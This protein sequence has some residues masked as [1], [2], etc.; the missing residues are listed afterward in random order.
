MAGAT[1][2]QVGDAIRTRPIDLEAAFDEQTAAV[3]F[4]LQAEML[5]ASLSLEHTLEIAHAHSIPVIVDAAAELPPKSNLWALAQRGAAL[6]LFSGGKDLRGPQTSGL[7]VG[8]EDLISAARIQ[9]APHE[10]VVGRPMK[11][12]KEIVMGML[13]AVEAYL[14]EDEAA[15]FAAWE[16]IAEYLERALGE[17]PALQVQRFRPTQPFIQPACIPRVAI[18]FEDGAPL[19]T[20]A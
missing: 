13:A 10:H 3:V 5:D 1:L 11:A 18:R 20:S 14:A 17:L 7:I 16:E 19:K 15:R 6:V 8:R 2:V 4:F 9:S 12:G